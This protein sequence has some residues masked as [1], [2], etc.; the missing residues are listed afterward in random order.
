MVT[1]SVGKTSTKDAVI[2]AFLTSTSV[3]GSEKSF[4]SEIGVPLTIIGSK[5]PWE[6]PSMWIQVFLKALALLL[7]RRPY[8]KL[9]VLEVGA[10]RPGD[11][12]SILKIATPDAVVVT[13]LPDVPV[14]VE[15]YASTQAVKDEEFTPA[16]ALPPGAPLILATDNE[17]ALAM[18]KKTLASM[19]TFGFATHS[20]VAIVAPSMYV[21]K[22]RVVGMEACLSVS[23]QLHLLVVEGALGTHQ[24]LAP[25]AALACALSLGVPAKKALA[26]LSHYRAPAGRARLL[27]G[28]GGTTLIDDSYNSSPVAVEEALTTLLLFPSDGRKVAVLGDMLELGRYSQQ[29]H[30]AAGKR[31]ASVVQLLITVGPRAKAIGEAAAQA[32]LSPERIFYTEDSYEAAKLLPTLVEGGDTVL[33][34][35]SQ[36]IRLERVV[37]ALLE[38]PE[39]AQFLVRQEPE[40]KRKE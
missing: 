29:E 8:P 39:D 33:I 21:K 40:W 2:A 13:R 22:G 31:A 27:H 6:N 32:G 19:V 14:H 17:Y 7:V 1:G 4:N 36:G 35:G 18:G 37:E 11:L 24:L 30:E 5:N 15:A 16:F 34:K 23:G 28:V 10:D 38:N 9:L 12:A 20:D 3:R 26:G 25:A